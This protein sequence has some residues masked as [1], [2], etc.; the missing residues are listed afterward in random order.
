MIRNIALCIFILVSSALV[1]QTSTQGKE[2]NQ[3]LELSTKLGFH[4]R[5]ADPIMS[6]FFGG[7][8]IQHM[9]KYQSKYAIGWGT[10]FEYFNR[11][12]NIVVWQMPIF[13]SFGLKMTDFIHLVFVP[14]IM[15]PLDGRVRSNLSYSTGFSFDHDN[16]FYAPF[17]EFGFQMK[18]NEKLNIGIIMRN[19]STGVYF[20]TEE[21]LNMFGLK[22][23]VQI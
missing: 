14:G 1:A 3:F 23:N 12:S 10:G 7:F 8:S 15:I 19:Q 6:Q 21:R 11:N 17:A 13:L 2:K 18:L 20:P 9:T 5:N 16:I 22:L 4:K